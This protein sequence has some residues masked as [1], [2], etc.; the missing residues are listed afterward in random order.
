MS[1][2]KWEELREQLR[3]AAEAIPEDLRNRLRDWR[4]GSGPGEPGYSQDLR[5]DIASS[6]EQS[7]RS[8]EKA[9]VSEPPPPQTADTAVRAFIL[10]FVLGFVLRGVDVMDHDMPDAI[11]KWL[12][13]AGIAVVDY[14][15]V[16][17]RTAL[18]PRFASTA[19]KVGT[20]FRWWIA[21]ILVVL[22]WAAIVPTI[23]RHGWPSFARNALPV[24]IHDPPTTE[25]IAK[26]TAP[27]QAQLEAAKRELTI[28]KQHLGEL[29]KNEADRTAK[30]KTS[31]YYAPS[32]I[33][34]M[35]LALRT[36]RELANKDVAIAVIP[37]TNLINEWKRTLDSV[38]AIAMA[39]KLKEMAAAM[40]TAEGKVSQLRHDEWHYADE[41]KPVF[42]D[43]NALSDAQGTA[44]DLAEQLEKYAK[45]QNVDISELVRDR[46]ERWQVSVGKAYS[47]VT[48]TNN[49]IDTKTKQLREL[50]Q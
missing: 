40:R 15:Y 12:I 10:L 45:A 20:D 8:S 16:P 39:E 50:A 31:P 23:E 19:S 38:G 7:E 1:D 32:E 34:E 44:L 33:R 46:A 26:A 21:A 4:Q 48:N 22:L 3:R 11:Q 30:A 18:G 13:A 27:I 28:T 6:I 17:V 49:Q 9:A 25:D 41:L 35:L 5:R 24:V 36:L 43:L 37:Q 42:G 2:N 29:E 14:F 47:W